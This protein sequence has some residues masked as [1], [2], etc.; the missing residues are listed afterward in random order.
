[1]TS[2]LLKRN[3]SRLQ[4]VLRGG[5]EIF[6]GCHTTSQVAEKKVLV[7]HRILQRTCQVDGHRDVGHVYNYR[8][9]YLGNICPGPELVLY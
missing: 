4:G 1:M 6:P 5:E 3:F 7:H 8:D 2:E 9:F